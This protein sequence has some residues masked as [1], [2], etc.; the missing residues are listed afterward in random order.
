[1]PEV[2]R[3]L[4][5]TNKKIAGLASPHC[6]GV[7]IA[8]CVTTEASPERAADRLREIVNHFFSKG[9]LP[10]LSESG[11]WNFGRFQEIAMNSMNYTLVFPQ[12]D[13]KP[14]HA[15]DRNADRFPQIDFP[16]AERYLLR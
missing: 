7:A 12:R 5:E 11:A 9:H 13:N 4:H 3:I 6:A 15:E 16:N 10:H 1:M 8:G 2:Q 14:W